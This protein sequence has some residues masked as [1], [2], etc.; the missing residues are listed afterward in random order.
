M[1]GRS[2]HEEACQAAANGSGTSSTRTT[3]MAQHHQMPQTERRSQRSCGA[4]SSSLP[5]D[6]EAECQLILSRNHHKKT[7][8]P[9]ETKAISSDT[10]FGA[11]TPATATASPNRPRQTQHRGRHQ[12]SSS[13][14]SSI[15]LIVPSI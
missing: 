7:A 6:E 13:S 4:P 14:S 11:S 15:K 12:S 8:M 3:S 1:T 5:C 10:A 2:R 9:M